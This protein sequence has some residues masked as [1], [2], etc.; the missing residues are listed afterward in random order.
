MDPRGPPEAERS[1]M[2]RQKDELCLGAFHGGAWGLNAASVKRVA[3]VEHGAALWA[4][5]EGER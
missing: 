4:P 1:S 2:G 3:G 5:E